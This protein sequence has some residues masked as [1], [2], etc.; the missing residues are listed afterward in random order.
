MK[1]HALTVLLLCCLSTGVLADV[2]FVC[3]GG[4]WSMAKCWWV[5]NSVPPQ[6]RLPNPGETANIDTAAQVTLDISASPGILYVGGVPGSSNTF[7]QPANSLQAADEDLGPFGG[8]TQTGGTNAVASELLVESTYNLKN[9]SLMA[10]REAVTSVPITSSGYSAGTF[11]QTQGTNTVSD[12]LYLAAGPPVIMST[13]TYNLHGGNLSASSEVV[14]D[15]GIGTFM[16]DGG[17]NRVRDDLTLADLPG[18]D[19]AYFLK[20]GSLSVHNDEDIGKSGKGSFQQNGGTNTSKGFMNLGLFVGGDGT[21]SLASGFL[22]VHVI[23]VGN[24]GNGHFLQSGGSNTTDQLTLDTRGAGTA[25]YVLSGNGILQ[26]N[27]TEGIGYH[28]NATFTQSDQ[29][30]HT[31]TGTFRI[32]V[33]DSGL[34]QTYNLNGGELK[35]VDLFNYGVFNFSGGR[36]QGN[37]E[38]DGLFV[39]HG[40]AFRYI[41][42]DFYNNDTLKCDKATILAIAG[43]YVNRGI[44]TT[45]FI[46]HTT[47]FNP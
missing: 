25:D 26:V 5:A 44:D 32:G 2:I 29:T 37:I 23:S 10:P 27:G 43:N 47:L 39:V 13:G 22:Q 1:A 35:T 8:F 7:L 31:V 15:S 24:D 4:S 12:T 21:Y 30:E 34:T 41:V 14:G 3:P 36:L 46:I 9:G 6:Y 18:S 33:E 28:G 17:T 20:E 42:G 40:P 19:G 38:N 16:Q 45:C 11:V